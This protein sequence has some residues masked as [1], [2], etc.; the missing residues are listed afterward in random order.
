MN[1]RC[2]IVIPVWNHL[3]MTRECIDSIK[4]RTDYPHRLLIIDNASDAPT[5]EYLDSL[6]KSGGD[7]AVIIRNEENSGFV[8]AVNQGMKF[9]DAK[10]VCIMNNDTIVTKGWLDEMVDVLRRNVNIGI[11]NPSS[12]TSGQFPGKL[13]IEAYSKSIRPLKGAYQE[14]YTGRAFAMIVKREVID[15]VG[16]LDE[17]YGMGYFDD[18][19][20]CKR[21]QQAGYQ[22]VRAKASYVYHKESQSFSKIKEK[23]VIFLKNER[24]FNLKW[25]RYLRVAYVIPQ[26]N[27]P[28]E[29]VMV[30]SNINRIARMGHQVW[31]FAGPG[32]ESNLELIDHESIRFL[33]CPRALFTLT[34][35]YKIW[36]RRH[37]KNLHVILTNNKAAYSYSKYFS[38]IFK[39][40]LL[41]DGDFNM[42]E[43]KLGEM[44]RAAL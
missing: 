10:Y 24:Q 33:H 38:K 17:I 31:I 16:Y 11:I 21:A 18:T 22:T 42:I 6:Q 27:N 19:D 3:D 2:D 35:L 25:G 26:V 1:D 4:G 36:E 15:K 41:M 23:S 7:E 5:R 20:Y 37:K 12:N 9:S 30:S 43:R 13:S 29:K 14:L 8:K 32:L 40:E 34:A 28:E 44:S 39:A